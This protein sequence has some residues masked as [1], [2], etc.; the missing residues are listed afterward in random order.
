MKKTK[1]N[2][3]QL[4]ESITNEVMKRLLEKLEVSEGNG[5]DNIFQDLRKDLEK[6]EILP[7]SKI[8]GSYYT[9][10]QITDVLKNNGYEYK[11][12]LGNKLHFFN[13]ETSISLYVTQPK[14]II[15]LTP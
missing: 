11:K 10:K 3:N 6:I 7:D 8:D 1:N 15:S 2:Y 9:E 4:V 12:A 14:N 13:K 5:F